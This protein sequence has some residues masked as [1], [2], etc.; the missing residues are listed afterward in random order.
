MT[1]TCLTCQGFSFRNVAQE[2]SRQGKGSCSRWE[3]WILHDADAKRECEFHQP[4]PEQTI[5]SRRQFMA[6]VRGE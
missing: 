4:A 5:T 1:V 6:K 2:W 3:P